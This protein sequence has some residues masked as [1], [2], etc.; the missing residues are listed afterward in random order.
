MPTT[1]LF[2]EMGLSVSG[3]SLVVAAAQGF[4]GQMTTI[5]HLGERAAALLNFDLSLQNQLGREGALLQ[6]YLLDRS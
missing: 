5:A 1:Y 2:D 6:A 3:R 4:I